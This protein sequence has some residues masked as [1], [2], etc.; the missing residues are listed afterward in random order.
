VFVCSGACVI[1]CVTS[2]LVCVCVCVLI[3]FLD[4]LTRTGFD[5]NIFVG[6]RFSTSHELLANEH[7]GFFAL[8][9]S[10]HGPLL[11]TLE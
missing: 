2:D 8:L 3:C 4:P 6:G 11:V 7:V 10:G 5:K 9:S 1:V